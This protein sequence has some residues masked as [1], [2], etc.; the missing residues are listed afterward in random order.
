MKELRKN[1]FAK[2]FFSLLPIILLYL[3]VLNEFDANFLDI[4]YLSFNFSYILI[5]YWSLKKIK[6]FNYIQIFF[7]GLINDV[8]N[9]LP[10]GLSGLSF[11]LICAA[12]LYLRSITLRPNILNDWIYFLFTI[13]FVNTIHYLIISYI[14]TINLNYEFLLV[15]NLSTFLLYFF[16]HFIF[17]L[18]YE[19]FIGKSDV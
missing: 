6:N 16:S 12:T 11:L 9:G 2:N 4:D 8:V 7:A 17:G 19:I 14:F 18:Y 13:S 1:I 3:S 15:N 5:F 10:V